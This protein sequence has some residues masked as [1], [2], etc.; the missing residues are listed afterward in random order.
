MR[1]RKIPTGGCGR[2]WVRKI[3]IFMKFRCFGK[4]VANH[5]ILD[6]LCENRVFLNFGGPA[7][8]EA[9]ERASPQEKF[10]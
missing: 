1:F 4:I 8:G 6:R 10:I 5:E 7:G 2:A 3:E 9:L